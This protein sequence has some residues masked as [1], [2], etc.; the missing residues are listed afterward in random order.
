MNMQLS[1]E[2]GLQS[3][4]GSRREENKEG[5]YKERGERGSRDENGEVGSCQRWKEKLF[6][7]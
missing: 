4:L 2:Q 7:S 5:I 3:G 6:Y 1:E